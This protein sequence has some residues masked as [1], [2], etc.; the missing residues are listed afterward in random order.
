MMGF[1]SDVP[2]GK[3]SL[4]RYLLVT[5]ANSGPSPSLGKANSMPRYVSY[6]TSGVK[7]SASDTILLL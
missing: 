1:S 6:N 7:L 2:I 5:R 3:P 4:S